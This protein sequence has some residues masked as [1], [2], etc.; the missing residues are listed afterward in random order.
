MKISK[1]K[2]VLASVSG[3]LIILLLMIFKTMKYEGEKEVFMPL[4]NI[5]VAVDAGHGGWEP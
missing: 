4:N 2:A 3:L 5:V 1:G